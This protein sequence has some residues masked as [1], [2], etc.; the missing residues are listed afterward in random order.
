MTSAFFKGLLLAAVL[1]AAGWAA[2]RWLAQPD[3]P[4][5][6]VSL[7]IGIGTAGDDVVNRSGLPLRR[8]QLADSLLYDASSKQLGR[9]VQPVL[10]QHGTRL[11]LPPTD[12]LL[13]YDSLGNN[14]GVY[15]ITLHFHLDVP[16]Q[17]GTPARQR[18]YALAARDTVGQIQQTLRDADW[19][20]YIPLSSPRVAGRDSYD[21]P[22]SWQAGQVQ[23]SDPDFLPSIEEW[24][25]LNHTPTWLWFD[26]GVFFRL[27][28][29]RGNAAGGQQGGL[30]ATV[31]GE[32]QALL[33]YAT[34]GGQHWETARTAYA[35][36]VPGML[37]ERR[38]AEGRAREQ[39]IEILEDWIDPTIA[40]V[41]AR[42][43]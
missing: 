36:A 17:T 2:S 29:Y 21:L 10:E 43:R 31:Q 39:G 23:A 37:A 19:R 41:P 42:G 26:Q 5:P 3:D 9:P 12:T 25:A 24:L 38:A 34:D 33:P 28:Y 1:V 8:S 20:R 22:D 4:P 40:G 35:A 7:V 27:S 13:F 16:Q 18:D 32:R 11:V 14:D 6:P 15:E 30:R